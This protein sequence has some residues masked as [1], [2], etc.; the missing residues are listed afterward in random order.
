MT[1]SK[2]YDNFSMTGPKAMVIYNMSD[3]EFEIVVLKEAQGTTRK[4]K[5]T[6]NSGK[7]YKNKMRS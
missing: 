3:M 2:E 5:K 6:T 4:H 7:Q 1:S